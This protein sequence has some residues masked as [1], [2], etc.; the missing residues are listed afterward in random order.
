GGDAR[1]WPHDRL[2][3]AGIAPS[4]CYRG[5]QGNW[6]LYVDRLM[7]DMGTTDLVLFGDCRPMHMVAHQ[8]A[9][10]RAVRVHVFEE[11]YV[12]PH[13]MSLE[14]DGVNGRSRFVRDPA[15][16][17][18]A[19]ATAP[20]LPQGLPPVTASAAR[21][22]RDTFRYY[23]AVALGL[24]RFPFFR[25]HRPGSLAAEGLGWL[26]KFARSRSAARAAERTI[27]GLVPGSYFLFPLQLCS[28]YQI[29]VHSP[30]A[31]M[32]QAV[33]YVLASFAAHAPAD[34]MLVIKEHP[35]DASWRRWSARI[36][37][38][39]RRMGLS[40]RVAHVAG[41]NL[42]ELARNSRGVVVVNSTAATFALAAGVPVKTLGTA[43]YAVDGIVHP[44]PLDTFWSAPEPPDAA[45]YE[46]M[47][48]ALHAECLVRGGIASQS[49]VRL[50]VEN[51]AARLLADP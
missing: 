17:L 46:A 22:R 21:R 29:R 3:L 15:A 5:R 48:R 26:R 42:E 16:L 34:A 18:A 31:Q 11:G 33:D 43:I 1:D 6:A 39:A 32:D 24:P 38:R 13:W 44:G 12:R 40:S 9:R 14:R 37:R 27:A 28:D 35:L 50:L 8:M 30:F 51:A 20:S 10:L 25:S 47:L 45:L 23:A 36:A 2:P 49:A 7:R 41:G 19:G 4:R